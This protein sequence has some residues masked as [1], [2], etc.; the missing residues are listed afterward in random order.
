MA[1]GTVST[2]ESMSKSRWQ[3]LSTCEEHVTTA[4]YLWDHVKELVAA[5][6]YLQRARD[7]RYLLYLWERVHE[8]VAAALYLRRARDSRYLPV[9][10]CRR[11]GRPLGPKTV[12][13]RWCSGRRT[14]SWHPAPPPPSASA[15]GPACTWQCSQRSC[16]WWSSS[17][18]ST[19]F[20]H[21]LL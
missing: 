10:S 18:P 6:L 2:C 19:P 16:S 21:R 17:S 20:H 14:G 1:A 13:C 8:L 11:A 4:L 5:A 15:S 12:C 3:Q 9:R 7:S